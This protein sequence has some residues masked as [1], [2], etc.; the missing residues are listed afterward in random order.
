[1]SF[2]LNTNVM[3]LNAL[4]NL[5]TTGAELSQ[6][7]NRLSTGL[8]INSGADDPAGL[9]ISDEFKAQ[10]AGI[11]QAISNNQDIDNYAKTADSALGQITSLLNDAYTL[12]VSSANAGVLDGAALQANQSQLN[13]IIQSITRI[14]T[15]TEFGTKKILDGS[16]GVTASLVDSPDFVS[17]NFTGQFGGNAITSNSAIT[18]AV[19]GASSKADVVTQTFS[20]G[21]TVLTSGSFSINGTTFN[22]GT[23]ETVS[24]VVQQINNAQGTTGVIANFTAGGAIT[25]TQVNYGSNYKINLADA[26]GV[27]LAAAGSATASGTDATATATINTANGLVTVNFT[28]G[29][30][31]ADGLSLVDADGNAINLTENGNVVQSKLAGELNVGAT[32]F[33]IGANANETAY[34]SIANFSAQNLGV[35]AVSGLNLSNLDLTTANG[36]SDAIKVL[37]AAIQQVAVSQGQIGSFQRNI[38][39]ANMASLNVAQESL[40]ATEANI[41]DVNVAQE[42]TRYTQLQILQQAGISVLAQANAQ[43]QAIL[44]L[45][46]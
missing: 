24:Q 7:V 33:Q 38:V 28:G 23:G 17:L 8:R 2:M 34:L 45:L 41:A 14:A 4:T 10:L 31:G 18:I 20:F 36:A 15:N 40:S 1:M 39:E 16:A 30:F 19:T 3:A 27:L 26:N 11:A 21:T 22:V 43:P 32:Q 12:A 25:L 9:I 46:G 35:G 44:K 29:K 6:S 5:N 42:M 37:T 13:S